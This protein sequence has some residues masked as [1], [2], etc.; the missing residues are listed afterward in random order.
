VIERRVYGTKAPERNKPFCRDTSKKLCAFCFAPD[1]KTVAPASKDRTSA[2]GCRHGRESRHIKGDIRE[3][4]RLE[5]FTK[6]KNP[7]VGQGRL[8]C[9]YSTKK[10]IFAQIGHQEVI[11][12]LEFR[13]GGNTL[14]SLSRDNTIR[15]VGLENRKELRTIALPKMP[16]R[17]TL[18]L[19]L[20]LRL[21]RMANF[22]R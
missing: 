21:P 6:R 14:T 20:E 4:F 22:W 8:T 19:S 16:S 9:G 3:L 17:G 5:L 1:G 7:R 11:A 10:K 15:F 2:M 18:T 13:D 12:T